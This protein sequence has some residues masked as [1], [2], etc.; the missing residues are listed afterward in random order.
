MSI[1]LVHH[2]PV[3]AKAQDVIAHTGGPPT[4]HLM[5]VS[6]ELLP[7]PAPTVVHLSMS[8]NSQQSTLACINVTDNSHPVEGG[9]VIHVHVVAMEFKA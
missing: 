2:C 7:S 6:E 5:L 9:R 4:L 8:E 3:L 1:S